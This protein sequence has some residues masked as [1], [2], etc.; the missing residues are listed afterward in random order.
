ML[1]I[2]QCAMLLMAVL[3]LAGLPVAA[4]AQELTLRWIT[5]GGQVLD[6]KVL[7]LEELDKL[8]QVTLNTKTPWTK[9]PQSFSGPSIDTLANLIGK[10]VSEARVLALND[11]AAIIPASDWTEFKSILSTRHN[12]QIMRVREKGPFWIMYPID[13]NPEFG[14]QYYQSR[15][16]WQ[17]KSIDF[18]TK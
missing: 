15:M 1:R 9:G 16:V 4:D 3:V 13:E 14:Q 17:V 6:Q 7:S 8:P 5:P 18:V 12:G 10:P 11:Y 2:A